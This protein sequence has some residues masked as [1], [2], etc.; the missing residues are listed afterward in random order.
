[1]SSNRWEREAPAAASIHSTDSGSRPVKNNARFTFLLVVGSA[2]TMMRVAPAFCAANIVR[3]RIGSVPTRESE[4]LNW[5]NLAFPSGSRMANTISFS[6]ERVLEEF[7]LGD[8]ATVAVV[9]ARILDPRCFL[10][11]VSKTKQIMP[12]AAQKKDRNRRDNPKA[13]PVGLLSPN[14]LPISI[15]PPS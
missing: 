6:G 1:M 5:P 13:N 3:R 8:V 12:T 15:V 2:T 14:I 4:A 9:L 11:R 7:A 10:D